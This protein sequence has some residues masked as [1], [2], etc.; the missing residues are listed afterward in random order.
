MHN[1]LGQDGFIFAS[2]PETH[3]VWDWPRSAYQAEGR[4]LVQS[5]EKKEEEREGKRKEG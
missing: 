1:T 2:S 5:R 3:S 4:I